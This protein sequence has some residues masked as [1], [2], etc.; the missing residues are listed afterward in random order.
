MHQI[1]IRLGLRPIPHWRSLQRSQTPIACLK[2]PTFKG[3]KGMGKEG[4]GRKGKGE[5][6]GEIVQF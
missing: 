2:G 5:K 4:K 1:R 3:R 6:V